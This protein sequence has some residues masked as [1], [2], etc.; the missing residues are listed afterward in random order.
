MKNFGKTISLFLIVFLLLPTITLA[1]NNTQYADTLYELGLFKGTDNGYELDKTF[2]REEAATVL[3]R[4][5]GEER[6]S[7]KQEYNSLFNDVSKDRWSFP[8]VMYCY[9]NKITKGTGNDTFSPETPISAEE[10]TTLV[11]RLL[12]YT[13]AEPNTALKECIEYNLLNSEIVRKLETSNNFKRDDM[14]YIVYRSL[15]TKT[16]NGE[17]LASILAEKGVISDKE[18]KEFD[19]YN[20]TDNINELLDKL[21]N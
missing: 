8:Y 19:I 13:D 4:L 18:S 20:S 17:I 21:L 2:T 11:L 9:E 7:E 10:F 5:L 15:M 1:A 12:G 3:V 14:V 16:N 6:D